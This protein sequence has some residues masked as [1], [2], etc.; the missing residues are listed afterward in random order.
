MTANR[1]LPYGHQQIDEDDIAAVTD[2]L[3][4][5]FLTTGP[6]VPAFEDAFADRIGA[7]HAVACANGTAALHLATTAAGL[8][9]GDLAVVP[10]VTFLATAN[11]VRYTG[12][13]V[14]FADVD[15]ETGLMTPETLEAALK[16]VP[17][18]GRDERIRAVL[19]VHL[20]GQC[21]DMA[22]IRKIA[23]TASLTV[24]EDACHA[25]GG[26]MSDGSP[27]GRCRFGEMAT[28]SAHPVKAI[29]MGE[30]GIVTTNDDALAAQLRRFRNHG[31][32]RD[33][34]RFEKTDQAFAPDGTVNPWYYEMAEIGFNYR[35]SD[36]HCALGLSQL[37]K[38]DG[39][40]ARRNALV[41]RYTER[42]APLAPHARPIGRAG[43]GTPA[44]HVAVALIDFGAAGMD[45]ASVMTALRAR[46][47]GTQVLY[48]PLYRQP[49][50]RDRYGTQRLAGAEA[51]Y[52]RC[53]CLPL[54]AAMTDAEVDRAT[55]ALAAV[56]DG[57][58]TGDGE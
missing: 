28:F 56:L 49:Y 7:R 52:A 35:A 16:S 51:Y 45:R 31:M 13:E 32:E 27:V 20:N 19:P 5:D 50:Y 37:R 33:P 46:G 30:G 1:F 17:G 55:D 41:A 21:A 48:M 14:I 38:L 36:I 47:V 2:V 6:T 8:G 24:I 42:L 44:W 54:F 10:A 15:P 57:T 3:R 40:I 43:I 4:S 26:T 39:F 29:A 25:L 9:P 53:L 12:A 22:A 11:A 18:S 34:N 23:D 58:T